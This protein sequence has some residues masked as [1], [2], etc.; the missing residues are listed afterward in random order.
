MLES[1]LEIVED[2]II[3]YGRDITLGELLENL[4]AHEAWEEVN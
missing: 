3:G 1:E 2:L 4:K